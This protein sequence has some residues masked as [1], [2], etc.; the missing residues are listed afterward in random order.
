MSLNCVDNM[1]V[2]IKLN[3][4]DDKSID[5]LILYLPYPPSVNSYYVHTRNGSFIGK[6]G[7]DFSK[8]VEIRCHEQLSGI[9]NS[10]PIK[11]KVLMEVFLFPPDGRKRDI[12]NPMKG[13]LDSLTRFGM[14][15]DDSLIDQLMIY[16]GEIIK[17]GM[18]VIKI[19]NAGPVVKKEM[20]ERV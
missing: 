5:N 2:T 1:N 3:D 6:K 20:I 8:D 18:C 13:L 16:R 14:W 19:Y 17:G 15:E 12:D 4:S 9:S 11:E 10:L 7:K